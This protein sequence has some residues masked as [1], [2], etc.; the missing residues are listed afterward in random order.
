MSDT[1]RTLL[2]P[3]TY[4]IPQAAPAAEAAEDDEIDL[5][6]L[7]SQL[8][9]L[10]WVILGIFFLCFAAG[11][12]YAFTAPPVYLA[13]GLLQVDEGKGGGLSRAGADFD[14]SSALGI[15]QSKVPSEI[16]II[17]SRS[18]AE[19]VVDRLA[20]DRS[21]RPVRFPWLGQWFARRFEAKGEPGLA[22][23]P[24]GLDGYAWGGEKLQLQ[25]LQ[26]P[27][28]LMGQTLV[29][30]V[31][32]P[33]AFTVEYDGDTI[34]QGRV[35]QRI[36]LGAA[37]PGEPPP[38]IEV[39]QLQ[40]H[41]GQR[42]QITQ[43]PRLQIV[44]NLRGSIK[45]SETTRNS[46]MLKASY[47]GATA[48]DA[49]EVLQ[50]I[51]DTYVRQNAERRSEEAQRMLAF[52]KD[53]VPRYKR[54]LDEAEHQLSLKRASSGVVT[55]DASV[56]RFMDE[57]AQLMAQQQ[58]LQLQRTEMLQ[59]YQPSFD[60]VVA[61]DKKLAALE[62]RIASVRGAYASLPKQEVDAVR[63]ERDV[64]VGNE[65]Y[66]AMLSKAQELSVAKAGSLA[67]VRVI[68]GAEAP[69][70]PERPK[71]PLIVAISAMLGLVLGVAGA[72][73]WRALFS[74]LGNPQQ[75]EA[76]AAAPVLASVMHSKRQR[77]LI[78]QVRK[79]AHLP[80][81]AV[82]SPRDLA[83][84]S[85]RSLRTSLLF[86]LA[87]AP[88][89]RLLV[90]GPTPGVGKT[91]LSANL[92]TVLAE[93]GKRVLLIDADLRMGHLNQYFGLD[94]G[95]GLTELLLGQAQV[96][97]VRRE[98]GVPKLHV[99]TTGTLPP[100]PADLLLSPQFAQLLDQLDSGYDYCIIDSPPVLVVSD[101]ATL[102]PHCGATL[103]VCR[104]SATR[105]QEVNNARRR[106]E[107]VGARLNGVVI[108][109]VPPQAGRYYGYQYGYYYY[110]YSGNPGPARRGLWSKLQRALGL[111]RH[112]HPARRKNA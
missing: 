85:V 82:D 15:N 7:F 18:V 105:L 92:A 90:T 13:E 59:R 86:L 46:G 38:A 25:Y 10:R 19:V 28:L 39:A 36:A 62:A 42:F 31:T 61:I 75:V 6:A 102:A 95:P 43:Y 110:H 45:A 76:A 88:N 57:E 53:Q 77:E 94:R 71:R 66:L 63:V 11:V 79:G 74:G 72:L 52:L 99:V 4:P 55:L 5:R 8:L 87:G 93:S 20:L 12:F 81:L 22:P 80:P 69:A 35:G 78:T 103:L 16:D 9:A 112:R 51:F 107:H 60:G 100:N 106:L 70:R 109:D 1:D 41:P 40:A 32:A 49:R 104:H 50:A 37:Q 3:P 2:A 44:D 30:H 33:D 67:S 21:V 108:N 97:Q 14:I 47:E 34:A 91:F 65:I 111:G 24:L 56:R 83:I 17:K 84:E 58:L 101:T 96:E 89:H 26:V 98:S 73:L 68:D 23:A 64:K 48:A 54:E 29:L 27:R